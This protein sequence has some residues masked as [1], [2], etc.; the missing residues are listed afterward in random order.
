ME[1][2][3]TKVHSNNARA[4]LAQFAALSSRAIYSDFFGIKNEVAQT[5]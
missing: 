5:G 1:S 3:N 2:D 4:R